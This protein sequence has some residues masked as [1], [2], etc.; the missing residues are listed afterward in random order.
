MNTV[1]WLVLPNNSEL[2][3]VKTLENVVSKNVGCHFSIY[4]ISQNMLLI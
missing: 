3:Y 4:Y 2:Y 1:K